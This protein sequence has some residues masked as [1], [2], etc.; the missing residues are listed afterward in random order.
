[1]PEQPGILRRLPE[2]TQGVSFLLWVA[3][4]ASSKICAEV[5]NLQDLLFRRIH[6]PS[7]DLRKHMLV[8]PGGSTSTCS[9][10]PAVASDAS[11]FGSPRK[12]R[13]LLF[14]LTKWTASYFRTGL[15]TLRGNHRP[16]FL[17]VKRGDRWLI[18]SGQNTEIKPGALNPSKQ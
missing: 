10:T 4:C 2:Q 3:M 7:F 17:S 15:G 16:S 18:S 14:S 6:R 11:S 1:M 9:V 13:P 12:T 5:F 8:D